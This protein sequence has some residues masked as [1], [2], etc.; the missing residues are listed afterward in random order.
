MRIILKEGFEVAGFEV[1]T[2]KNGQEA[3]DKAIEIKPDL[4]I[5]DY[6]MPEV[7]GLECAKM[8]QE[9]EETKSIPIVFLTALREDDI[10]L[11]AME[12]NAKGYLQKPFNISDVIQKVQDILKD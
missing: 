9:N 3:Y 6:M 12:L 11:K 8:L 10:M 5:L 4:I 7:N 2:A 1:E